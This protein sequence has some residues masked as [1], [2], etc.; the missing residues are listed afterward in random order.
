MAPLVALTV[1]WRMCTLRPVGQDRVIGVP[2]CLHPEA[3]A[4][5]MGQANLIVIY[6]EYITGS[7]N[8]IL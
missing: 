7:I 1:D 5:G 2:E 6:G 3:S 8:I 4:V